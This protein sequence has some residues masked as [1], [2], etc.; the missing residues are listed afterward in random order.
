MNSTI[1]IPRNN[2]Q[3]CDF[4]DFEIK[5]GIYI[6]HLFEVLDSGT[7]SIAELTNDAVARSLLA[8]AIA[9]ASVRIAYL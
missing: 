7:G 8:A 5:T 3:G 2:M 6:P 9:L 1:D 4:G